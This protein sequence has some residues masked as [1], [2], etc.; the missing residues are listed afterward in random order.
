MY[1]LSSVLVV[2]KLA[3]KVDFLILEGVPRTLFWPVVA[4]GPWEARGP[5][6]TSGL[7]EGTSLEIRKSHLVMKAAQACVQLTIKNNENAQLAKI[8]FILNAQL[9]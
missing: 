9:T 8:C 7:P 3:G 6:P 5:L 1:L 2:A 4:G